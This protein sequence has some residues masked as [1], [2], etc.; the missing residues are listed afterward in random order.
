MNKPDPTPPPSTTREDRRALPRFFI[1]LAVST[2]AGGVLGWLLADATP[3]TLPQLLQSWALVFA[4][5]VAPWLMVP[6]VTLLPLCALLLY[7]RAKSAALVW[8]GEDEEA[9][10]RIDRMMSVVL[11]ISSVQIL[12]VTFL[13]SASLSAGQA[14]IT[15]RA[16]TTAM[17]LFFL[18]AGMAEC[19]L[20]QQRTVNLMKYLMPE[21]HGSVFDPHFKDRW[22][23]GCDEAE[24]ALIGQCAVKAFQA[25][26]LV[27]PVLWLLT[28][29]SAVLLQTGLLPVLIVTLL[30]GVNQG[31]YL[32]W[33][34]QFNRLSR[35]G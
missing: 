33:C 18:I 13:F 7:R 15:A 27:C 28:T 6:F 31:V 10:Q 2:L 9:Y 1:V 8:D 4:E 14:S 11:I 19:T 25:T 35:Q 22:M 3:Q 23:E 20:L 16:H 34:L 5:Q 21:K 32:Y 30:W 12:A 24:Q 29:L 17:V 26:S